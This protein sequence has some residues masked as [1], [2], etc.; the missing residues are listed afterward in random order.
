MGGVLEFT[1]KQNYK[2]G[3]IQ[4]AVQRGQEEDI[5]ETM[6][7]DIDLSSEFEDWDRMFVEKIETEE[8]EGNQAKVMDMKI[9]MALEECEK[10]SRSGQ[11]GGS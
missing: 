1:G 2:S 8:Y 5:T 3:D 10:Q 7:L 9:A 6:K 4:R 11:N